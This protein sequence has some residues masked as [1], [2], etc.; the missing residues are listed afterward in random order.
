MSR[1]EEVARLAGV[2]PRTVSNVVSGAVT[3]APA[4]RQRVLDAIERLDYRPSEIG[5]MLR[6]GRTGMIALVIPDIESPYFSEL[7]SALTDAARRR[8]Y[9]LVIEQ[10]DGVRDRELELLAR[11]D[12]KA[13]FDG[14]IVNPLAL[15]DEDLNRPTPRGRPIVLLGEETHP[16]F[17][18]VHID[19][20]A[21]AQ[22]AVRHLLG[23][24]RTRILALG[25]QR[26]GH[27]SSSL[28]LAGFEAVIA[29]SDATGSVEYVD[30][31]SRA[32]GAAAVE[33]V[34]ERGP[35][36]DAIFCFSDVLALG[37]LAALADAGVAVPDE[38]AVAGF[39]DVEDGRYVRPSLTTV[40]PAKDV[41]AEAAIDALHRRIEGDDSEPAHVL[42]PYRLV[43]RASTIS[44]DRVG[45]PL[46]RT[47]R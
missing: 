13:V 3:V 45:A 23:L 15:T 14:L 20:F 24:G 7:G 40:S 8:G 38:V 5:R 32:S 22:D 10:T 42:A 1:R 19:N 41:I 28:R 35:A 39:D 9:T 21:A 36:P 46:R 25:A 6:K 26:K 17:D 33:R 4:T 18:H 12:T 31:F 11:A 34:L 27:S 47:D 43:T 29:E 30:S 37:A 44:G 2:S 16:G